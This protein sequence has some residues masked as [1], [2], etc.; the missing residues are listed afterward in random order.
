VSAEVNLTDLPP[1]TYEGSIGLTVAGHHG[2]WSMAPG[3]RIYVP[4]RPPE[5]E[6]LRELRED[7]NED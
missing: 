3:H 2:Q 6:W 5:P 4:E 7:L 1:G